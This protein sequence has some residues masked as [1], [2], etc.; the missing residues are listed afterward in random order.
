MAPV[1]CNKTVFTDCLP[2]AQRRQIGC[3][4]HGTRVAIKAHNVCVRCRLSAYY[5]DC[6]CDEISILQ[7]L[8]AAGLSAAAAF[9]HN[10]ST[11]HNQ[12]CY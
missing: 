12:V 2:S 8:A 4:F 1:C 5:A 9:L 10:L 7:Y 6:V 11:V 3:I